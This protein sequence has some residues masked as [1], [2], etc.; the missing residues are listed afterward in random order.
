MSTSQ[1]HPRSGH[2]RLTSSQVRSSKVDVISGQ[3]DLRFRSSKVDVISGQS[4]LR[5]TSSQVK[6]ISG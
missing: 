1:G 2:L 4:H 3:G 6:V 5:L